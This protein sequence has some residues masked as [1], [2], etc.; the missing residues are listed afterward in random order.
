MALNGLNCAYVPLR[1]YSLT[2]SR[3]AREVAEVWVIGHGVPT[4]KGTLATPSVKRAHG[5]ENKV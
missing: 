1:N 2:H 5:V 3:H 4:A